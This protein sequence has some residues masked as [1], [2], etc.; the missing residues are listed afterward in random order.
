MKKTKSS[1]VKHLYRVSDGKLVGGESKTNNFFIGLGKIINQSVPTSLSELYDLGKDALKVGVLTALLTGAFFIG[2][3]TY[4]PQQV[5]CYDPVL[6]IDNKHELFWNPNL[7]EW[8]PKLGKYFPRVYTAEKPKEAYKKPA[9]DPNAWRYK[10]MIE[11]IC[12]V[13]RKDK[14]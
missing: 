7:S 2:K 1:R 8:E 9:Q 3:K 14:K 4:H 10:K 6:Y 5:R 13:I 11:D 12:D